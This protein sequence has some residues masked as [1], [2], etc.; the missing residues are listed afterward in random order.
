RAGARLGG[1]AGRIGGAAGRLGGRS[2]GGPAADR[3]HGQRRRER[4]QA[5]DRGQ[6]E[7]TGVPAAERGPLAEAGQGGAAIGGDGGQDGQAQRA[8]HL[9][10]GVEHAGREPG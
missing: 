8:A 10:G 2:L 5:D 3:G 7:G 6:L 4:Q 1:A 9:A